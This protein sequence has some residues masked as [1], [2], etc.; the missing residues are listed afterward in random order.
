MKTALVMIDIQNDY[1][2]GGKMQLPGAKEALI[3]AEHLLDCARRSE[4]AVVHIR[5]ISVSQ[6]DSFFLDGTFGSEI[7]GGVSPVKGETIVIKHYPNSFRQTCLQEFLLSSGIGRI[8]FCGM[9]SQMCVD[10]T[11]RAA[12]DMGYECILIHDACAAQMMKFMDITVPATQVH[13]AFMASIDGT[14]ARVM[15]TDEAISEEIF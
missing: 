6:D 2:P 14:F 7:N 12:Y 9:M 5:H 4:M 3:K 1:F 8:V 11:V 10:T 15:S 13:A